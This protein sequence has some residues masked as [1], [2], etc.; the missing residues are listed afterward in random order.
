MFRNTRDRHIQHVIEQIKALGLLLTLAVADVVQWR[1][2]GEYDLDFSSRSTGPSSVILI[3]HFLGI[4]LSGF[5][6]GFL[7]MLTLHG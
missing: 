4:D 7:A 1:K 3:T 6:K 2:E 5:P